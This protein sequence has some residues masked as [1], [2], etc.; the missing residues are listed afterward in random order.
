MALGGGQPLPDELDLLLWRR[1]AL[2]RFLLKGVKDVNPASELRRV[3]RA[4][5]VLVV[6]VDD[7][8]DAGSPEALQRLGR[9]IGFTV[10]RG[11]E[12]LT[13]VPADLLREAPKSLP[14]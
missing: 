5:R 1:Y 6:P 10:L 4:V 2:L 12:G 11:V 9:G 3:D 8:H 14:A 7:L 13:D